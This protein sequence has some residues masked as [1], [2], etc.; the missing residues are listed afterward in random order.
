MLLLI[1]WELQCSSV[2]QHG[3]TVPPACI[4]RSSNI[5]MKQIL[6]WD[7]L[8]SVKPVSFQSIY[9]LIISCNCVIWV[10]AP[11][12]SLTEL[13]CSISVLFT[14]FGCTLKCQQPL[15]HGYFMGIFDLV[16]Q[17]LFSIQQIIKKNKNV[18][19]DWHLTT[20]HYAHSTIA[21]FKLNTV[22]LVPY[23]KQKGFNIMSWKNPLNI[24][25]GPA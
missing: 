11:I 2:R 18:I 24:L 9:R 6:C 13:Q 3:S 8:A 23:K 5:C 14:L 19:G 1:I 12:R 25:I 22:I 16:I 7:D 21:S 20:P 4:Y 17:V 15:T 10:Y